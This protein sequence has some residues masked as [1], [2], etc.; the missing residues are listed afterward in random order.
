MSI[1][2]VNSGVGQDEYRQHTIQEAYAAS[3]QD[4][5]LYQGI[6]SWE[7]F[8][9]ICNVNNSKNSQFFFLLG[10]FKQMVIYSTLF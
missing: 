8:N 6:D 2:T 3:T 4:F 9:N 5:L 1:Y 10:V 7:V